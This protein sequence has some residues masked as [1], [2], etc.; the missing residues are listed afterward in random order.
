MFSCISAKRKYYEAIGEKYICT[1]EGHKDDIAYLLNKRTSYKQDSIRLDV[2]KTIYIFYNQNYRYKNFYTYLEYEQ[3]LTNNSI[4]LSSTGDWYR[5]YTMLVNKN[6]NG[7][8]LKIMSPRD[9]VMTI[10]NRDII[11][12]CTKESEVTLEEFLNRKSKR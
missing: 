1:Y 12:K 2:L 4:G 6:D 3:N 5:N 9:S 11:L 8:I 10:M 7:I